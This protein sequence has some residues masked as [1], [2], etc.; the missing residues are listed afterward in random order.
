[1]AWLLAGVFES[2]DLGQLESSI[3][4][5]G[6]VAGDKAEMMEGGEGVDKK[7]SVGDGHRSGKTYADNG[8][9]EF[10]AGVVTAPALASTLAAR[11]RAA[12]LLYQL[13]IT[14]SIIIHLERVVAILAWWGLLKC[15][16]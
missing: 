7:A 13:L 3:D 6:I 5:R 2:D 9:A 11:K 12:S 10:H 16:E 1:M 4:D 14:V 15:L 8:D